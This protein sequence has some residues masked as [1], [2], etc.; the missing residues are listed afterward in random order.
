MNEELAKELISR[1]LKNL[2]FVFKDIDKEAY[3]Q[4]ALAKKIT[5]ATI[6]GSNEKIILNRYPDYILYLDKKA[7]CVLDAKASDVDIGVN[8]KA[9]Q[10]VFYYAINKEI[11]TPFYA[12]CNGKVFNLFSTQARELLLSYDVNLNDLE[13]KNFK[14]LKQYLSTPLQSLKQNL[15]ETIKENKKD[16]QWYLNRELPK[17]IL[18]PKKRKAA[19]H[20]GCTG[21]F[22]K[23]SWDI[24]ERH[25]LNFTDEGD[26]V[27][28]PF[29]GSGVTAIEA[30]MKGRIGIHTDLNPLSVFMVKAL[31]SECDLSEL[32]EFSEEIIKEFNQLKPKNEKEVK[33]L[34]KNAK[35]YPNAIDEEFGEI[36]T[37]K[38]QDTILWIPKDELLPK[39][40]DVETTLKLFSKRQLVELALLRKLIFKKTSKDR[41]KKIWEHRKRLR[42]SLLLAFRNVVT[43]HNKTYHTNAKNQGGNTGVYMYYRYRVAL[44]PTPV[45]IIKVFQHKIKLVI[46][47]KSELKE[48]SFFYPSYYH[49]LQGVIKDFT[50]PL[51]EN[52]KENLEETD[53]LLY[54]NNGE[55][56]FQADATNLKEIESESIDF[57]YT[58]PPYGAKIPYLDLS[59]MWN[60]W[61]DFEVS[62]DTKE[63]ECIE[64]GSLEKTR[65]DYYQ[66]MKQSLKQM[67]RVLKFNRWLAF[68]FQHQ[69]PKL[70]Q[71]IIESAENL[72]FEYAGCVSQENT[73]I[74]SFKK[75]QNPTTV[76]KGQIIIYFKKV[77]NPKARTKLEIGDVSLEQMYKDIEGIIVERNGASLEH[78]HAHLVKKAIEGGY[79]ALMSEFKNVVL[80][81]N[82]RFDY[83]E[84]TKLYHI[85]DEA[86]IL[87]YAIPVEERA[88]YYI[89]GEL[90]K[91]KKINMGVDFDKLC[92][93]VL[94]L[95]K[96]G[97]Q[98]NQKMIR[99]ILEQ[100]GYEDKQTRLWYLKDKEKTLFNPEDLK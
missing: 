51:L 65:Y 3:L 30:M 69:D 20:F 34:L 73:G 49:G 16:E 22:T 92:L 78:I 90:T 53:S 6:T 26:V 91:A 77:D 46:K 80:L 25:I 76:L 81:I 86:S 74:S 17:A 95:L 64:K 47:G 36:A 33:E 83:E 59:I 93:Y 42:Y 14:L 61:L 44:K 39:G 11:K 96:N 29:G 62:L 60:V 21:Y 18:H 2:N 37:Q 10:Q 75:V 23:Q 87:N 40:S 15:K 48:S 54:K 24:L 45:D 84:N 35:Y 12:L 1:L 70:F 57:I 4:V 55:K 85:R 79:H 94:P 5:S 71:I 19:R 63:K 41:N 13:D 97:I 72:G 38:Q 32:Y 100:L 67:Y 66:L 68:V 58:D 98:A 99:E 27:F 82:E 8:S 50:S 28:D 52:R 31:S 43:M 89:L 7:H 88:K 9:E 56:I